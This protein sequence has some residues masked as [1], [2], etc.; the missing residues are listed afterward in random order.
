MLLSNGFLLYFLLSKDSKSESEPQKDPH[1][2]IKEEKSGEIICI[3][4]INDINSKTPLLSKQFQN[5]NDSIIEIF[6]N[7]TKLNFVKEYQ[8]PSEGVFNIKYILNSTI[9]LD[10]MFKEIKNIHSIVSMN[11][12]HNSTVKILSMKRVFEGCSN[13][14][15]ISLNSAFDTSELRSMSKLFYKSGIQK[16]D[17]NG[18]DTKYVED[19][20][21]MFS[22]TNI[23]DFT[24]LSQL[25]TKNVKNISRMFKGCISL[26]SMSL[27]FD[28]N[29]I[30]DI[31]GL[32]EN[33]NNLKTVDLSNFNNIKINKISNL[34]ANCEKLTEINGIEKLNTKNIKNMSK[35]FYYCSNITKLD[36]S[37]FDTSQVTNFSSMFEACYSLTSINLSSF[38]THKAI[39]FSK[40]FLV[41]IT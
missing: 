30:E 39:D 20:S 19:M 33:C 22:S 32:F 31:S 21:Y 25:N 28:L 5:Y 41:V 4:K 18:F 3:Y 7:N 11:V 26:E 2:I 8:F 24:F 23:S 38:N 14:E 36:L 40:C 6:I 15:N 17:F 37:S 16:I 9:K 13:L 29:N 1:Q 34:F 35:M 27:N 12:Y 10:N